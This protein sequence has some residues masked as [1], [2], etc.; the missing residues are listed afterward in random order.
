MFVVGL[1]SSTLASDLALDSASAGSEGAPA[2]AAVTWMEMK[3]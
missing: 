1:E 2:L 3:L